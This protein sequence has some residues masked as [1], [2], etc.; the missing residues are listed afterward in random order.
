MLEIVILG[1]GG[2]GAQTAGNQLA[3]ALF[4]EGLFVQVF[5]TYGGA[6]RGTPVASSLRADARPI[7][8]RSDITRAD[9]LL[10]FDESLMNEAFLKRGRE[11]A[12][13]VVNSARDATAFEGGG[14]CIVPVDGRAIARRNDMGKVV[15]SALLGGFAA[16]LGQ[17]ALESICAVIEQT[18]PAKVAQNLAACREAHALVAGQLEEM[19]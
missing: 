7:R 3:R 1:R 13:V 17:P 2:Q 9:A 4:D 12:L 8:L 6:R 16:A 14:R 15:N 10:C 5:A 18:A 11:G 19:V